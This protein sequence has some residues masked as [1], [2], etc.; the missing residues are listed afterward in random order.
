[1]RCA[2]LIRRAGCLLVIAGWLV[3]AGQAWAQPSAVTP[4]DPGVPPPSK[5]W[6]ALVVATNERE[7][8][9]PAS[10]IA[11]YEPVLRQVFGYNRFDLIGERLGVAGPGNT[12]WL[13]P[14]TELYLQAEPRPGG[15][16]GRSFF[17]IRLFQRDRP[18]FASEIGLTDRS[19]L[20]IRGPLW[21]A[22]QLILILELRP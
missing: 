2:S 18:L 10:P 9:P 3:A 13:V 11:S 4:A 15:A 7:P 8:P 6:C 21:G 17:Q 5:L 14:S 1:M 19:P 22:G 12:R 20:Y 16:D